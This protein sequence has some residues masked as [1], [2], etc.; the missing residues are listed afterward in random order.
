M[1]ERW[2]VCANPG[3]PELTTGRRCPTHTAQGQRTQAATRRQRGDESMSAYGTTAWRKTRARHL[4]DHPDC[5]TCGAPAT[6]ADHRIPRQILIAAGAADPDH[7]TW[8]QSL[9]HS[10]HATK[11]ATIDRALIARLR[12]G[13]DPESLTTERR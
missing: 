2:K 5:V 10:C 4:R 1:P 13:E 12:D 9:C 8:L 6:D 11:T 3:C 7:P